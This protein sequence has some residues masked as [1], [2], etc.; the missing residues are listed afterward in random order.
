MQE[1][2]NTSSNETARRSRGRPRSFDR[3][4]VLSRAVKVFW[5]RGYDAASI[6]DLTEALGIKR[7]SL[8][9]EFG[10]KEALFLAAIDHYIEDLILPC[11]ERLEQG[12]ALSADL[13]DFFDAILSVTCS[14]DGPKGCLVATVLADT[15]E[16][17]PR[18][19]AKLVECLDALDEI[20]ARRFEQARLSGDLPR[21]ADVELLAQLFVSFSQGLTVRARSGVSLKPLRAVAEGALQSL[22]P[23]TPNFAI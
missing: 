9:H 1:Q 13:S 21:D 5:A 14:P 15:A 23:K 12:Q 3:N 19:R 17:S 7:S 2:R 6:E 10:G 18:F 20:F 22:L 4:E 16:N 11:L 8:Y